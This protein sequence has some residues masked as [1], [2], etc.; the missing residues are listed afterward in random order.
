MDY[1][2]RTLELPVGEV[3]NTGQSCRRARWRGGTALGRNC[4]RF[5]NVFDFLSRWPLQTNTLAW[6]YI[7]LITSSWGIMNIQ[8]GLTSVTLER[9]SCVCGVT[10]HDLQWEKIGASHYARLSFFRAGGEYFGKYAFHSQLEVA[11]NSNR[12]FWLNGKRPKHRRSKSIPR[13][14][15]ALWLS[16]YCSNRSYHGFFFKFGKGAAC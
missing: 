12:K 11:E 10:S 5:R 15:S 4:H 7:M 6:S 16:N 1:Y 14:F 13:T 9:N 8:W 3:K 2:R